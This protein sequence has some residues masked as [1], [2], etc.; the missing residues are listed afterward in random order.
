MNNKQVEILEQS[1]KTL[2]LVTDSVYSKI[3]NFVLNF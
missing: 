3:E 2:V 1:G